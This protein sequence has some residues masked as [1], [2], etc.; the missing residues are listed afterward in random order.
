M[1]TLFQT[2]LKMMNMIPQIVKAYRLQHFF[3]GTMELKELLSDVGVVAEELQN[4][5]YNEQ[6]TNLLEMLQVIVQAQESKDTI[7]I[8][9]VLEGDLL[10]FLQNLQIQLQSV[11][12]VSEDM[13]NDNLL[14]LQKLDPELC[15]KIETLC[16]NDSL[17]ICQAINGQYNCLYQEDDMSFY[18]HSTI[19]PTWESQ[20]LI[21]SIWDEN[22]QQY[23]VW[24]MGMGYH[25]KSLLERAQY[26][27]VCVLEYD[28]AMIRMALS[29]IDF[30]EEIKKGRLIICYEKDEKELVTHI[31]ESR[32]DTYFMIHY[33]SWRRMQKGEVK[34][35]LENYFL[36][37]ST[38][39]ERDAILVNNFCLLQ[40]KSLPS[41]KELTYLFEGKHVV[42]VAGGPSVDEEISNIVKY[43]DNIIVFAVG[44]I[45]KKLEKSNIIPDVLIITDPSEEV[46]SQI[47]G[48]RWRQ[49]PLILLSTACA[50][51][52]DVYEGP[53]YIAYQRLY[54]KAKEVAEST[55]DVMVETGGSVTTTALDIAIRLGAESIILVGTDLAYTN[56]YSH[57]KGTKEIKITDNIASEYHCVVSTKGNT[58]YTDA[59]LD[60]FRIWIENR[61]TH[62]CK[63]TI[64]NTGSGAR[65]QGTIEC[66]LSEALQYEKMKN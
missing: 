9:D 25:V 46:A 53:I 12:I 51:I 62:N 45:A 65:I 35:K 57:A 33:P 1:N 41:I 64:Y 29:A 39:N 40:K 38:A 15:C 52:S 49:I 28:I 60:V 42:I 4:V 14:E 27:N 66:S 2:N 6:V 58:I 61:L 21:E 7:L 43:R 23:F 48:L 8:A 20:Q 36:K 26:Y 32:G 30:S 50:T 31:C 11:G 3:E 22:I 13:L 54:D 37:V 47:Q 34:E 63:P 59:S 44:R 16:D 24:G 56:G 17:R 19:N 10:P 55:G 18:L 5:G